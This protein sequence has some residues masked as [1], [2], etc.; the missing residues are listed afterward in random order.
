M[1]GAP[2][3]QG[4]CPGALRPM[5]SGDGL[6]VRIRPPAGRLSQRQVAGIAALATSCGNGII[7]LS[8]RA[9][10]QLRGVAEGRYDTLIGGLRA[11][12][13]IDSDATVES[14]RNILITPFWTEGDA[15]ETLTAELTTVLAGSEAPDVSAKF[16]YA[17]DA[18]ASPV[19][20][21]APADI[22]LERG[23]D[24][25]L[26]VCAA[27]HPLGKPVA[28]ADAVPQMLDLARWSRSG[29]T[30]MSRLLANGTPLPHGFTAPRQAVVPAPQPGL[31]PAGALVA[32][33]FGQIDA[34]TLATLAGLGPLRVTP[35]RMLLIEGAVTLP[36]R[37]SLICDPADP[38]LRV[39]ACVGAP[40]CAQA[41][42]ATRTLARALAR[43]VPPGQ[44]LHVSGCAK[45]CAMPRAASV[46]LT[47][48]PA[49]FDLIRDATA[50]A[51]PDHTGLH[52]DD[53]PNY[54]Q[55]AH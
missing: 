26:L 54:L 55:K 28:R 12:G 9:N 5:M 45:G 42:A 19:L 40:S 53:L 41:H 13:L 7:D 46:T 10:V 11:L 31:Y 24:G 50:D 44:T 33:A 6:I 8:N 32:T 25:T 37:P 27:D 36:A 4:R 49:G 30:R 35:W 47:A 14:R 52:T 39:V 43:H 21:G 15:S 22:R 1:S 18:G 2:Q 23:A 3:I 34:I 17:I 20:Q 16:G 29:G 38:L 48:T 51:A